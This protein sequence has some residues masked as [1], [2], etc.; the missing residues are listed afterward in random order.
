MFR[1]KVYP[2]ER[3]Y[4]F[5]I[6]P[7]ALAHLSNDGQHDTLSIGPIPGLEFI[8]RLLKSDEP[9]VAVVLDLGSRIADLMRVTATHSARSFEEIGT[10]FLSWN[11]D[12]DVN[13]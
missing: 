12:Y 10:D 6:H 9:C 11:A 2:I 8:E 13:S 5:V 3:T 7:N 1:E 4:F